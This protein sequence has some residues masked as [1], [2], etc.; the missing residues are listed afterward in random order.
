M[1][2]NQY[3]LFQSSRVL[4]KGIFSALV[5]GL[6]VLT[7]NSM[8]DIVERYSASG[9]LTGSGT[10]VSA[11]QTSTTLG[12]PAEGDVIKV[13]G[14]ASYSPKV[15]CADSTYQISKFTVQ[16]GD[17]TVHTVTASNRWYDI[18]PDNVTRNY[19]ITISDLKCMGYSAGHCHGAFITLGAGDK[20]TTMVLTL[21]N[22]EV[23][24]FVGN[25]DSYGGAINA[26]RAITIKGDNVLFTNNSSGRGGAINTS[27]GLTLNIDNVSFIGNKATNGQGGAIYTTGDTSITGNSLIFKNNTSTAHAGAI[28]VNNSASTLTLKANT[29]TFEGNNGAG[30]E[31]GAICAHT[32]VI[33]GIDSSSVTTFQS[34]KTKNFGGAICAYTEA[35]FKTGSFYFD[36]NSF[37]TRYTNNGYGGGAM[38]TN[39]LNISDANVLSFTK[40]NSAYNGGAIN[41]TANGVA[42]I[43]AKTIIFED[44]VANDDG[45]AIHGGTGSVVNISGESI[46]FARNSNIVGYGGAING[47]TVN[48]SGAGASAVFTGNTAVSG[49]ND[50][51]VTNSLTF[52]DNGTYSFDGGILLANDSSQLTINK[53]QVTVAGRA[54]DTTND[55]QL[56]NVSISNGG[57]LTANLDNINS[58]TGTFDLGY[59]Y[60]PGTLELN[61]GAGL[62][63]EISFSDVKVSGDGTLAK[64]G[65]GTLTLTGSNS[66]NIGNVKV[67]GGTLVVPS[68]TTMS[69]SLVTVG[70]DATF[71]TGVS[72]ISTEFV[73]DEGSFVVGDTSASNT[74]TIGYL[75]LDGGRI[76]FDF[77]SPTGYFDADWLKV[78]SATLNSGYIDLTF[79]GSNADDWWTVIHGYENGFSVIDG[80][81]VDYD[82]FNPE[83][84]KVTINGQ[85]TNSW[86]LV[87]RANEL[88]LYAVEG[89]DPTVEPW[90]DANTTDLSLPNWTI[91][92]SVRVGAKFT[93]GGSDAEYSKEVIMNGNGQ[94]D[95]NSGRNLT[96][97]N[98]VSGDGS[99]T[100]IG[101]GTLTLAANNTYTGGTTISSGK[102]VLINNGMLGTGDVVNNS[103]LEFA[104]DSAATIGN[105]I[106][107]TGS[108][109]MTG[110]GT[111]TLSG[112]NSYSGG[113]TI[114]AG[115]LAVTSAA[116]LGTGPVT[117]NGGKLDTVGAGNGQTFNY[118]LTIGPNGGVI[119]VADSAYSNFRSIT[120]SGDL[121]TSGQVHFNG[122]GGYNGHL[123]VTSGYA[124]INPG[125]FG[126]FDLTLNNSSFA[127]YKAGTIQIGKLNAPNGG[128]YLFGASGDN[129][130]VIEIGAGTKS[131][132]TASYGQA[133]RGT[134]GKYNVTIKKV[135]EGTQI[136]NRTGYGYSGTA[137]SIKEVI[138]DGGKM[139]IDAVN[140]AFAYNKTNGFWGTATITINAGGTLEYKRSWTVAPNIAMTIN[141]GTLT[142]AGTQYINK[143]TLN[144]GT[145][146]GSGTIQVGYH[147]NATWNVKGGV[148][149][150][151][152]NVY[153][154]KNSS[155]TSFTINFDKDATLDVKKAFTGSSGYTGMNV[156]LKGTGDGPGNIILESTTAIGYIGN[157]TFNNMNGSIA[158]PI[159][160]TNSV[161]KTGAGTVTLTGANDY[162]GATTVSGGKLVLASSGSLASN[163]TI[164][165][166]EFVDGA[167]SITS[168]VTI[169]GGTFTIGETSAAS[170]I[171]IGDFALTSGTVNFDFNSA[172]TANNYDYLTTGA[173]TLTSGSIN[174]T[175]NS[176]D[177]AAW[178]NNVTD[179]GYVLISSTAMT[180]DLNSISLLINNTAGTE[181]WYLDTADNALVLKKTEGPEPPTPTDNYYRA[182]S[183][184]DIAQGSWTIDGT[185]KLGVTFTEG[186]ENAVTYS[187]GVAM[188]ANGSVEVAEGKNLTLA[189]VVSGTGN[190]EKTGDGTLT[191]SGDNT[192]TGTTTVSEGT[193]KLTKADIKG[194]LAAGS[195][196]T[197]DGATSVLTGHGDILG[198]SDQSVGTINLQNGGT[199]HNDSDNSHITVGAVVNMNNGVISAED[200]WGNG[201]FGNFVFDNAINVLGGT[202]N[203][204]TANK[205]TLRQYTGTS[206]QEVGGKI[207]VAEG[208]KLTISSQIA[209]HN[210]AKVVPL[211]KLGD[212]ELVL[213]GDSTYMAGTYV[214]GGTLTLTKQGEKGTLA[215]L[216]TVTV[217]GATS[218]LAGHGDILGYSGKTVG[219]I[220][221]ENGG[222][223]YNDSTD[224]HITVG[225]A[226]NMKHGHITTV[227]GAQGDGFGNYVFDNAIN[228][229]EGTD[230]DISAYQIT[231]RQYGDTPDNSGGKI[232]VADGA[233]LTVSSIIAGGDVP[234][235]KLGAGELVLSATNTYSK[236]TTLSEGKITLT[237]SGTLGTGA[238]ENSTLIE[239][240][241]DSD[242]TIPSAISGT[243]SVVKTGSGT[244]TMSGDSSFTGGL[245]IN[246]GKLTL[247]KRG[248]KGTLATGGVV[249]VD[250]ATSILAGH[251]DIFGYGAGAL[252]TV[253][254]QNNGKLHND[255]T[256]NHIT[257]G[258]AINMN[259]GTI[260]AENGNGSAYYG[261]FVFDNAINVTGGTDNAITANKITIR[262]YNGTSDEEV[263]G[264]ITVAKDAKL[265]ISSQIAQIGDGQL[266]AS[267]YVPL[268]KLGDGELV[269]SGDCTYT[270]GTY[271]NGGT[272]RLEKVGQKGTLAKDST[273]TVDGATSVLA[274]H[275]DILGY[276]GDT[277]GTVNLQN[278]GTL[279]NDATADQKA[280]IT[281]GAAINMNGGYITADPNAQGSD[282]YGNYVFD[283]AI[284]VTG[285]TDNEI[286]ANQITLRQYAGTPNDA[287][288]KI[289]VADG[290]KLT[291]S[292]LIK[293]P[294]GYFVPLVKQG[295]GEL[296]LTGENTYSTGTTISEGTLTL[297]GAGTTGASTVAIGD[298]G[299][300][301][302]YVT[303]NDAPKQVNVANANAI[304]G[305]GKIVKSGTGVL[306]INNENA[307]GTVSANSFAV[308]AGELDFK[309][310]YNGDLIVKKG[311]TL[312]PGNSVGDLTVYG[313]VTIDP[314]ATGLF[315]FSPYNENNLQYDTLTVNDGAFVI[316]ENSIIKLFFE[317]G[318]EDAKLWAAEGSEYRLVSDEGFDSDIPK[319]GN[320]LSWFDLEG[321]DDGLWL[322]GL[323]APGPGPEPGSGVP[324]PST[325]ALLILGVA[326][327]MY[328]R[329]RKNS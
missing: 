140:D 133:I 313:N 325:W 77:N 258:A 125:A 34:N 175:F 136:F 138:I 275:G 112:D 88:S 36:N 42:N 9:T 13:F 160:G 311:S 278:G 109:A 78:S 309:G 155:S 65:S 63:K 120:G 200:G 235:V 226:V 288:G 150:L 285:G 59:G 44:N 291:I 298:N 184:Q 149:T 45:G 206:D 33:N 173:A 320:Y 266:P 211:V 273:V 321:R 232:T 176:G 314:E 280:H 66:S 143:L 244:V 221:L 197:V 12:N 142:I 122:T 234:L 217:D 276:S 277:V 303:S 30:N 38:T 14:D 284:N 295:A 144:S 22:L 318:N 269:L 11:V 302:F 182:N 84:V 248:E 230:N 255:S 132:D 228:A 90:Y 130:Y 37:S 260:S 51:N 118:D 203:Q 187:G 91:D 178:W 272:L 10:N 157:I 267:N 148:T 154:I 68:T 43:A 327:L 220:N 29:I 243:G 283:N 46:S 27:N 306:K 32:V 106:S 55:Y 134:S 279:Y 146:N 238:V 209:D 162:T 174:L 241:Q 254:L 239:F 166:G 236:G 310:Q 121:S 128:Q 64:S 104:H 216:S 17:G 131:T 141:G 250:G 169:N 247:T 198:Y 225:A 199:L 261:N 289:T 161:T 290:A 246:A 87:A 47:E 124:R 196:V 26:N 193:L 152:N 5:L 213:S 147:G 296:V 75:T 111:V 227:Q 110:T 72:M 300:L 83:N 2:N 80:P 181:N 294:N 189:G 231:L 93:E 69:T 264:K 170:R 137:N 57:K 129:Q 219:T 319:L 31:G 257:V 304:S 204:I 92:G 127:I 156:T 240:A 287:G 56:R 158:S 186:D 4:T 96:L 82:K 202:E 164:S 215:S 54:S 102:L 249:T 24:G 25:N 94:F 101:E 265:T 307:D 159:T 97:S 153:F 315:E 299:T 67:S 210:S 224:A 222:T 256:D 73:L 1:A 60:S 107:G 163:V 177:E 274:G 135:G 297:A 114:S 183:E 53:A 115:T 165:G 185:N 188:E 48:F 195:T 259:S 58:F 322:I 270:T 323:Y 7:A 171:T 205:I 126:I 28:R 286:S 293:D 98:T 62:A 281:V 312:S 168:K 271:V 70:T 316:D 308:N 116:G 6:F 218:V 39:K 21:N 229:L 192:N 242:V 151:N 139:V 233:K 79:N 172:S 214:Y 40:N 71:K 117:I 245:T 99:V 108:V 179:S 237:K 253:N 305:T 61:V 180:A 74:I 263:G 100:K 317:G 86:T 292:S 262:Q 208:A 50:I 167:N 324:E 212:G 95:V 326:G 8:A 15:D 145:T 301:E 103:V 191:L 252:G 52:N 194:T 282:T 329:K 41:L 201:T 19:D 16:S 207:T 76:C 49:G 20:N 18:H 3:R 113:T 85:P 23:N 123:T 81:I 268:V 251:G 328:W 223:L 190:L 105:V 119:A 89:E 35:T